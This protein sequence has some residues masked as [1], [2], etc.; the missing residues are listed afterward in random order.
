MSQRAFYVNSDSCITCKVCG[1]ACKDKNDLKPGRKFRKIYS[2]SA[3]SWSISEN[4]VPQPSGVLSYSVSIGC[5]HCAMPLCLANCPMG[6]IVKRDDGI[7][8]IDQ[9][10]CD[11]CGDCAEA[12]PYDAPSLDEEAGKMGKCDF[13]MDLLDEGEVP[14]CV[15]A[16]SMQALNFGELEDLKA[17]H[18]EA[19]QQVAPLVSPDQ[20]SPSLLINPRR[21]YQS[22]MTTISI[23]MPEEI[24]ANS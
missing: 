11:G 3:G 18:P 24:Q 10:L 16:C 6:A 15:A 8:Y 20:T 9:A 4:G 19:V 23:N 21:G 12:C 13:C 14:V 2:Q 7:V 5:N 17:S 1:M 22:G